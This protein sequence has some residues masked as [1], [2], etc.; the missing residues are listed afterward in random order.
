[1]RSETCGCWQLTGIS[2]L[3]KWVRKRWNWYITCPTEQENIF[4]FWQWEEMPCFQS[5]SLQS[6]WEGCPTVR[7][8]HKTE[9]LVLLQTFPAFL[10]TPL[11]ELRQS[12]PPPM[13]WALVLSLG[14]SQRCAEPSMAWPPPRHGWAAQDLGKSGFTKSKVLHC[15]VCPDTP[16]MHMLLG[17]GLALSMGSVSAHLSVH[18]MHLTG[19]LSAAENKMSQNPPWI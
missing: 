5:C 9:F 3:L 11:G 17:A 10:N 8:G 16:S 2:H 7:S 18:I 15:L 13:C 6:L 4:L 1:M 12:E 19:K 14:R